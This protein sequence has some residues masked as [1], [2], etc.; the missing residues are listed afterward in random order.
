MALET[1][2]AAFNA[3]MAAVMVDWDNLNDGLAAGEKLN[4]VP[5]R[6]QF[7]GV[8]GSVIS[9]TDGSSPAFPIGVTPGNVRR[10]ISHTAIKTNSDENI[11]WAIPG[12]NPGGGIW[13]PFFFV[14]NEAGEYA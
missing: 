7:R 13:C 9:A 14:T 8:A 6:S 3:L 10:M 5:I 2:R 4:I 11:V 1:R 12:K